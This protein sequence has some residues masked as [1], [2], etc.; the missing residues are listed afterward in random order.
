MIHHYA[1]IDNSRI[2]K[3]K[4][5]ISCLNLYYKEGLKNKIILEI[6]CGSGLISYQMAKHANKVISIDVQHE[7]LQGTINKHKS[8]ILSQINF[9][10][11]DG[12]E[13]NFKSNSI[14]IVICNQV[15]EHIQ[16]QL[17]Q[18]LID[19]SYRVL[20]PNGI[21]YIATPNK[22][23]PIEPHTKL[24][25]LSYFPRNIANIYIRLFRK[26]DTYDVVLPT[27]Y[28]LKRMISLRFDEVIDL[29]PF[30]IMNPE[31]FYIKNE[32]PKILKSSLK[33]IPLFIL[34]LF[35]PFFPS[36]IL[37]GRARAQCKHKN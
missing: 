2:R 25:F 17:Q 18:Q 4:K 27:Y 15:I 12:I 9:I 3:A 22:L 24:P 33:R 7:S 36:W 28:K 31:K 32:I 23:W 26:I 16:K 21:F 5:I 11:S 14:D 30:V 19:E 10:I 1:I 35:S 13:L 6:G 20:K 34:K 37:I 29:T 8:H